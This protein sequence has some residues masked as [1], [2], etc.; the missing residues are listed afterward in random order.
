MTRGF[1]IDLRQAA[2]SLA[3]APGF[4]AVAVLTLGVGLGLATAI[5]AALNRSSSIRCRFP[6]RTGLWCC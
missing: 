1:L 3:R 4:T 2:R 5:Y 6:T